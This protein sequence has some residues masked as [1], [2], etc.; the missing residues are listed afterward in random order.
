MNVFLVLLFIQ[1]VQAF[2]KSLV[3]RQKK[4]SFV[5]IY[6]LCT[7]IFGFKMAVWRHCDY[8][9]HSKLRNYV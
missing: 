3:Q 6:W 8:R 9:I 5:E 4:K 1:Y 7:F 2:D